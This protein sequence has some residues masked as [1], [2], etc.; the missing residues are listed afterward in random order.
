MTMGQQM[1][2]AL[3]NAVLQGQFFPLSN[4]VTLRPNE[5]TQSVAD[6][7][8]VNFDSLFWAGNNGNNGF[9]T[10]DNSPFLQ[11]PIPPQINFQNITDSTKDSNYSLYP[12]EQETL[13]VS[14]TPRIIANP[15]L[16]TQINTNAPQQVQSS[17]SPLFKRG[18]VIDDNTVHS[19]TK[20]R[21]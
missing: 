6:T 7:D 21:V 10:F 15:T 14:K 8:A 1:D 5:N 11:H 19:P 3:Y 12:T 4:P 2:P 20:K 17:I 9:A 16:R 13:T 18:L